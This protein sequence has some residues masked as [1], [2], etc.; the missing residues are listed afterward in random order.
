VNDAL[1]EEIRKAALFENIEEQELRYILNCLKVGIKTFKKDEFIA[2]ESDD[3]HG[4]G[5]VLKG[6]VIIAKENPLGERHV[7]TKIEQGGNFGE[8][9]AF[10]NIKR[11]PATAIANTDCVILFMT[12]ENII[13]N[14]ERQCIGHQQLLHNFL[15]ILSKKALFLNRKME[16][17]S[18]KSMRSKL[19]KYILEVYAQSKTQL[20]EVPLNRNELSEFLN[21]SRPSMSRE[22]AKMKEEG[23]IDFHLNSFKILDIVRLKQAAAQ[24][25]SSTS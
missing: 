20:F 22:L 2:L 8:M 19:A 1:V 17:L 4:L 5:V 23:I 11:W 24:S 9:I 16:Y 18:I 7:V 25:A 3:Y 21:V 15:L 6:E 14:C 12:P 10:S 13:M